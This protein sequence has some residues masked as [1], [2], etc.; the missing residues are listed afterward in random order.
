MLT[1]TGGRS[2]TSSI[3]VFGSALALVADAVDRRAP[4]D[5]QLIE[6]QATQAELVTL[7]CPQPIDPALVW[8][9]R[10]LSQPFSVAAASN[11]G[12]IPAVDMRW[13]LG[14]LDLASSIGFE[15]FSDEIGAPKPSKRMFEEVVARTGARPEE[16]LHMEPTS[17][18]TTNCYGMACQ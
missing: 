3:G 10:R 2:T 12:F 1:Q 14:H 5:H 16:I 17:R 11:T 9:L 8:C 18:P 13:V 7:W 15:A 6:L 4:G